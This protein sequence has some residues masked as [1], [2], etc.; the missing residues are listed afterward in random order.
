MWRLSL[1]AGAIIGLGVLGYLMFFQ[2]AFF[3]AKKDEVRWDSQRAKKYL[4]AICK[5]GKRVSG[6]KGMEQQQKLLADHFRKFGAQVSLQS[7]DIAHPLTGQPV[8]LANLIVTWD[9]DAKERI[10]IG[11]H[12]D[13][14]PFPDRDPRNPRGLFLGA[15]D[16]ASGVALLME[17]AHHM[18]KSKRKYGVDFVFFDAEELIFAD[19]SQL[20]R[21]KDDISNYFI[22]SKYFAKQYRDHPPKH[23]YLC[24]AIVD[25][26][27]DRNLNLYLE[28]N[29][30]R[31][32]PDV[33]KRIWKTAS[34]L[35]IREFVYREKHDVNDDHMPLNTIAKIPT[36]DI[37]DFDYPY[38][39][40][41]GD[42]PAKCSGRSLVKVG[43]VLMKWLEDPLGN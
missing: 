19:P 16:G 17:M 29:S 24:G 15:N 36:C 32:A 14:R 38:W 39:H 9:P 35:R 6:T 25:M 42:T 10:L 43:R 31:Y 27:G 40:T 8:R 5:I 33:T 11:C 12:Y 30:L 22:G 21:G 4:D 28:K 41:T 26:V 13:T 2:N 34:S 7:F 20:G 3:A 18:K 37:I 23:R 1:C